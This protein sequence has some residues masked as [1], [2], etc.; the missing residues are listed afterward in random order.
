MLYGIALNWQGLTGVDW[1]INEIIDDN[2]K[3]DQ[4]N[5]ANSA[6]ISR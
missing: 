2:K 1:N 3:L 5:N 6:I 4:V